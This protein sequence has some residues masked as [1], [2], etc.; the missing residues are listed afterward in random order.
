MSGIKLIFFLF[1]LKKDDANTTNN[2]NSLPEFVGHVPNVTVQVGR[3]ARLAC[4]IRNL[5][6][7]SA[8]WIHD[9]LKIILTLQTHIITRD[10]RISLLEESQI[11]SQ[12]AGSYVGLNGNDFLPQQMPGLSTEMM[13]MNRI[14]Y[15]ILVIRNV[16]FS[17]RGGYMCQVNTVPLLKQIG[18]LNVVVPPDIIDHESS[19]DVLVREG[20]NV[21]LKCK[22]RGYPEPI[23]EVCLFVCVCICM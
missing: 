7:Y 23:I 1:P 5:S 8:A 19:N 4:I 2:E 22:A 10:P 15:F 9:D 20:D 14:R 11:D 6:T 12:T 3:E 18:Y 13:M 21:T 17:D 16:Q